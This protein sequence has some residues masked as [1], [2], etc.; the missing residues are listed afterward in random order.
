MKKVAFILLLILGYYAID[1]YSKYTQQL[2]DIEIEFN[3]KDENNLD[4]N[5]LYQDY[6]VKIDRAINYLYF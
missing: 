4:L 6:D 3:E 1:K 2:L 5:Q